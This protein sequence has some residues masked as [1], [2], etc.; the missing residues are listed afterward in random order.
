MRHLLPALGLLVAC[1]ARHP[2]D[3][4]PSGDSPGDSPGA[5]SPTESQPPDD[6]L[7]GSYPADPKPAPEFEATN[8]DGSPRGRADLLGHPTVLW[9]FPAAGTYG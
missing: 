8:R 2:T 7:Y 4:Q 5:D 6:E 1:A 9:F 3:T